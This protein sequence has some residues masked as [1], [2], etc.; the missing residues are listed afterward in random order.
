MT[1]PSSSSLL[2]APLRQL[3]VEGIWHLDEAALEAFEGPKKRPTGGARRHSPM[4][5]ARC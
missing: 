3:F 4:K 2:E 1:K 5:G